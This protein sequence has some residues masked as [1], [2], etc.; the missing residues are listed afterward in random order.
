VTY[1][2]NLVTARIWGLAIRLVAT[3]PIR[4]LAG[5]GIDH[6][7]DLIGTRTTAFNEAGPSLIA[8]PI[9]YRENGELTRLPPPSL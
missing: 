8:P 2:M 7:R 4:W 1:A 6:S 3:G 5:P 9:D